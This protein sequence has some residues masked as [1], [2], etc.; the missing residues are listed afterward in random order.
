MEEWSR[1]LVELL[2]VGIDLLLLISMTVAAFLSPLLIFKIMRDQNATSGNSAGI[3]RSRWTLGLFSP[4]V[5]PASLSREGL[6]FRAFLLRLWCVV[7]L[8]WVVAMLW[9]STSVGSETAISA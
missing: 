9:G 1:I 2:D 5:V 6:K 8:V 7:I 3:K 4:L